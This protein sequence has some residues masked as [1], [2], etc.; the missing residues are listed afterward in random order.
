MFLVAVKVR[1]KKTRI[2]RMSCRFVLYKNDSFGLYGIAWWFVKEIGLFTK[3]ETAIDM[4][5]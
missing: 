3:I 2:T 4:L 1:R 5:S